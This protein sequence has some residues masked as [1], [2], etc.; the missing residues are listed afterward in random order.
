M[1]FFIFIL[2]RI[3]IPVSKQWGPWSDATFSGVWSGSALSAYVPKNG[4]LGL[5]GLILASP[6]PQKKK[7]KSQR[8][9][10]ERASDSLT[11]LF[12][13]FGLKSILRS[14]LVFSSHRYGQVQMDRTTLAHSSSLFKLTWSHD[15]LKSSVEFKVYGTMTNSYLTNK[16]LHLTKVITYH[17]IF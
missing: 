8:R 3:D 9:F 6:P 7:Y 5:Y 13:H 1:Y 4:T 17:L 10:Y 2:I 15:S 14:N 16:Y 12:Y 11:L